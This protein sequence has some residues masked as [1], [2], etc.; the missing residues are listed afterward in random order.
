MNAR[1]CGR[2]L[3]FTLAAALS[4][5]WA[6]AQPARRGPMEVREEFLLAQPRLTLPS[7]SPDPVPTSA[8]PIRVSLPWPP[9]SVSLS[10]PPNR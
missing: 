1:R 3:G 10:S 8:S 4:P 6:R 5:L 2:L 7:L 9:L